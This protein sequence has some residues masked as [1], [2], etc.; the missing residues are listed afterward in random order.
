M[1]VMREQ[2]SRVIAHFGELIIN[3]LAG[4]LI[5]SDRGGFINEYV[6]YLENDIP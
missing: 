1:M 2:F 5:A 6:R 4:V 3:K